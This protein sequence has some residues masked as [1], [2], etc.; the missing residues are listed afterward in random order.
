MIHDGLSTSIEAYFTVPRAALQQCRNGLY[1]VLRIDQ[2]DDVLREDR[3]DSPRLDSRRRVGWPHPGL[4]TADRS[5]EVTRFSR[6]LPR[7]IGHSHA[8]DLIL[9][10]RSLGATTKILSPGRRR[11][12]TAFAAHSNRYGA[13]E[14]CLK[15]GTPSA[16][17]RCMQFPAIRTV[18]GSVPTIIGE[19]S[20]SRPRTDVPLGAL[21]LAIGLPFLWNYGYLSNSRSSGSTHR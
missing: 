21:A 16:R 8:M 10:S 7:L 18:F 15:A 1:E 11:P 17:R 14:S 2:L 13:A 20:T 9:T 19:R 3:P 5:A 4:D 12:W 6:R